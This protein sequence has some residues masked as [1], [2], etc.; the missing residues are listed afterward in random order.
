M[1]MI[2][3]TSMELTRGAKSG[4]PKPQRLKRI[5]RYVFVALAL[6]FTVLADAKESDARLRERLVGTW[7]ENRQVDC[8]TNSL[9][10]SLLRNGTFE[11]TGRIEGCGR[12]FKLTWRGKWEVKAGR[13]FYTTTYSDPADEYPVGVSFSDEIISV[14]ATEW[15]MLEESTG[16]TSI[17]KRVEVF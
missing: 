5:Y 15:T 17:A 12:S 9:N 10:I 1:G 2:A 13:F 4:K 3:N 7:H 16:N 8:E 11:V 6:G 14:T